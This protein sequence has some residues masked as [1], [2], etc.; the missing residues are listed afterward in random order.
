MEVAAGAL[1]VVAGLSGA[2]TTGI[3][4]LVAAGGADTVV[5]IGT[6]EVVVADGGS[7]TD[8]VAGAM[9]AFEK[10]SSAPSRSVL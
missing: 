3:L 2:N 7:T 10:E 6:E 8:P 1:P 4:E 9:S 5:V